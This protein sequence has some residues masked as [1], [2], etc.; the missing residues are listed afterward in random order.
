M[1]ATTKNITNIQS[2]CTP[3]IGNAAPASP[4][5]VINSNTSASAG[6]GLAGNTMQNL[7]QPGAYGFY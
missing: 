6:M 1:G 5:T 7:M 3:L 2:F 4:T